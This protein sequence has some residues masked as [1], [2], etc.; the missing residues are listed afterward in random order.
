MAAITRLEERYVKKSALDQLLRSEF[1]SN[2]EV[3]QQGGYIEIT[4][5]RK[6]TDKEIQDVTDAH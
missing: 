6:L 4:A 2:F 1:G 3:Q 5:A